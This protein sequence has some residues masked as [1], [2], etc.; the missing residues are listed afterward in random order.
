[1]NTCSPTDLVEDVLGAVRKKGVRFWSEN[2][3]LHYKA[4]IGALTQEE[5]AC[6]RASRDA[7]VAVLESAARGNSVN[8]ELTHHRA[9]LAFSQLAHWRLYQ[10]GQRPAV[11]QIASATRL[12]G[13]LDV[14]A[15]QKALA[16]IVER[17]DAL[18]T[19][20]VILD[21]TPVQEIARSG[22]AD[23]K[24]EDLTTLSAVTREA[25]VIR[26]S[27]EHILEPIDVAAGPLFGMRLL[28][29]REDE[30]VLIVAMEHMIADEASM[31]IL[32]RE[33]STAYKQAA[34]NLPFSLPEIPIQF[35]DYAAWLRSTE[36]SWIE[37]YGASCYER[38][39][40]C[41]LVRFPED[42]SSHTCAQS[43]WG[44]VP[45]QFGRDLKEELHEWSRLR[46]TT[47]VMS[48]FTAFVGLCLRWCD[49]SEGVVQFVTD[50]RT[51]PKLENTIGFFAS[52]LYVR[53]RLLADDNFI[54]LLNRVKEEYCRA[55]E[56]ADFSY[57]VAQTPQP[58]FTR[59][60]VFNWIPLRHPTDL[61]KQ[62]KDVITWSPVPVVYPVLKK[63]EL[64]REP[65][66]LLYDA[67]ESV[68]GDVC[69]PRQRFSVAT[70]ERF[71]RNL[72]MFTT[73][74]VKNS[75]ARVRGVPLM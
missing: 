10:L 33:I 8:T 20:I 60:P 28:R 64:N 57:M 23:L 53:T 46:Q 6:L 2:G 67:S 73:A 16:K 41:H 68:C 72:V 13:H 25:E 69:F 54:D 59:N 62:S 9:P 38:L 14:D 66:V 21:G 27:D 36:K 31:N 15:F 5:I 63:L 50:G 18:R 51:S 34:R 3:E 32:L 65:G 43:G 39:E 26:L 1:V 52:A 30:H 37:R 17:H 29:L 45:F 47:I 71:A 55:H 7:I 4:P 42:Q 70:M 19:R 11:R 40:R 61:S 22:S 48:V 35:A 74:L 24:I 44:T 58:E 12:S 56:R 75:E 49:V